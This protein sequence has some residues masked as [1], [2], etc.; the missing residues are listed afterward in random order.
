MKHQFDFKENLDELETIELS[1][2][3]VCYNPVIGAYQLGLGSAHHYFQDFNVL[4]HALNA[5]GC[6]NENYEPE[7]KINRTLKLALIDRTVNGLYFYSIKES[8]DDKV[9]K[10]FIQSQGHYLT[11][12][13]WGVVDDDIT[14]LTHD[15]FDS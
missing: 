15:D 9:I 10:E 3:T 2:A 13:S 1:N 11:Q 8:W 6:Q 7:N 14:D 4:V 12:C 5:F